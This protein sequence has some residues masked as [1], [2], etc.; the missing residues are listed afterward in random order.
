MSETKDKEKDQKKTLSLGGTLSLKGG[1]KPAPVQSISQGRGKT[2]AVEVRRKRSAGPAQ[3]TEDGGDDLHQLTSEEREARMRALQEAE[4]EAQ[5]KKEEAKNAPAPST[6]EQKEEDKKAKE[7]EDQ[8]A[9]ELAELQRIEEEERRIKAEQAAVQ[10]QA[11]EG[12]PARPGFAGKKKD[13]FA[14]DEEEEESYRARMKRQTQRRPAKASADKRRGGKLTVTQVLNEDYERDRGPS[15]A[16]QRRAREKARLAAQNAGEQKKIVREVVVPETITVQELANRMA[17]RGADV[18]K[19]L[20]KMGVMATINETIDADTAELL[21]EEFGHKIKRVTDADI[22]IGLEGE[23]DTADNLLPRPPVVTVMGHVDHGKTSLLDALRST[24]VVAG[25]AGGITQHI[26]AYQITMKS[27][28]KITFLDTPGH[29][30]FTEMRAR[31]ANVTDIVVLVVAANDSIMPQTIEAIH[32]A[33]AAGVP[34]I[35]AVN[36]ID[37]PDANPNKVKQDLLQHEVIVESLSGDVP[38][39]EISAK[40]KMGLDELEEIILLQAELLELK[41]NPNKMAIGTV[42]EAKLEQGRGHVATVL[43]QAGTLRVGDIFVV[44]TEWG[45]VR[46]LVND[47]GQSVQEAIPGEPVEILGLNGAPQAGDRF[48]VT[49]EESKARGISEYRQRKKREAS[50][51]KSVEGG[52]ADAFE[53]MLAAAREGNKQTLGVVIKGDVHGSIEAIEGSLR[54]IEEENEDVKIKVLHAGT[55][56]ITESDVTLANAS[57]GMIIGFNVR[58]NTQA[59]EMSAREGIEIRYYNIIYDVIDDVKN[60]LSGLLAPTQREVYLGQALI[61]QV[62]RITKVGNVAGCDVTMGNVKRGAHVRL[63]RDDVVIHEGMLKTLKRHQDEVKEVKEGMECGMAFENYE[64]IK[65]GDIIEC[66]EVV[67]ESRKVE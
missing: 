53:Q 65:E 40:K 14:A 39:V 15:L 10:Q 11:T 36:K 27:G 60:V 61:K 17:E 56:G 25:E 66:Y 37:L 7:E 13:I 43:V 29:A 9:K 54:K 31:G 64:D 30:A 47:R 1:S 3:S 21:I 59:R 41:A 55:G 48:V 52:S 16:A 18:I 5:R 38:C 49:N 67:E 4:K 20:M 2:V 62:F 46:A 24:D 34:M 51:V 12:T 32:H 26:G 8:R 35:V 58:A 63:L 19:E 44:G 33:K 57:G 50:N 42:V 22:E 45:R 6:K 28:S 23:E